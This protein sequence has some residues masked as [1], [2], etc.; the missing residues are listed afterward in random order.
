MHFKSLH[1][2]SFIHYLC[3]NDWWGDPF[4]LKFWIKVAA[5]ERNRHFSISALVATQ[6]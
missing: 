5:L 4:Y 6:P 1:F 2:H 3:K